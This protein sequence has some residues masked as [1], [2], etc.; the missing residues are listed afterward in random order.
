MDLEYR[1]VL[2]FVSILGV[3]I[4]FLVGLKVHGLYTT[5]VGGAAGFLIMLVLYQLGEVFARVVSRLRGKKLDEVALGFGD[6]NLS[7]VLGLMLGW[8]GITMGLL[9]AILLGGFTS[10]MYI[11]GAVVFKRYQMF[12]AIPY[13]PFLIL[14]T[15]FLLYR[16]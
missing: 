5:L 8:P 16:P 11:L 7:G 10:G 12:T 14:G 6:V 9:M 3:V 13:A 1:I 15:I 2:H 4:G